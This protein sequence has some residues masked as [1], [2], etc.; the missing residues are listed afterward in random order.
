[1]SPDMLSFSIEGVST[2]G[3]VN[4]DEREELLG[5][6]FSTTPTIGFVNTIYGSSVGFPLSTDLGLDSCPHEL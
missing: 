4:E 3:T 5:Q 1:M 6:T 2:D